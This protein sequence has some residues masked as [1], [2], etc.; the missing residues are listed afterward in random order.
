MTNARY[1]STIDDLLPYT[2][3]EC[4]VFANTTE[5]S[6]PSAVAIVRTSEEGKILYGLD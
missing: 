6:G 3:Y 2:V 1:S 4:Y 5:G